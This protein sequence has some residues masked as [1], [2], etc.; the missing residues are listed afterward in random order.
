MP[1]RDPNEAPNPP[2]PDWGPTDGEHGEGD[3]EPA[4]ESDEDYEK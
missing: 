4:V 3:K 1:D 2:L